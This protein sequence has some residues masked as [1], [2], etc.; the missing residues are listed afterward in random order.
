MTTLP[1]PA[2]GLRRTRGSGGANPNPEPPGGGR[3]V[4]ARMHVVRGPGGAGLVLRAARASL[5]VSPRGLAVCLALAAASAVTFAIGCATG[6]LPVPLGEVARVLVGGGDPGHRFIV[7]DLRVPRGLDGL[8]VGAALGVSGALFQS[9]TRNPLGSPDIVGFGNGAAT[10]AL[11]SL[12]WWRGGPLETS[13][14]AFAGGAVTA[15]IV[16]AVCRR[17]GLQGNRLIVVGIGVSAMAYSFNAWLLTRAR[18]EDAENAQLW[19]TGTLNGRGWEHVVPVAVSL[20]V[21]LPVAMAQSRRLGLLGLGDE[22]ARALGVSPTRTRALALVTAVAL[23]GV[24][25]A[26]AG[27]ITFVALAAPQIARLLTRDPGPGVGASALTGALL[28]QAA[29]VA[30]QW[31]VPAV[32]VPAGLATGL[33]GGAYLAWLLTRR[34]AHR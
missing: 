3:R 13:L 2:P 5:R 26:S 22:N 19:L 21:L 25:T 1:E 23:V 33:T 27:P 4:R 28:L 34:R 30:A 31:A 12:L 15:L 11:L 16:Q 8:L 24:A 18:L 29:D 6:D 14:A 17:E 7:M 20:A 10:G 9:V 32:E